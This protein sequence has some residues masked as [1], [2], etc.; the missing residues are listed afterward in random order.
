MCSELFKPSAKIEAITFLWWGLISP[1]RLLFLRRFLCGL[2]SS[3]FL[4]LRS[5]LRHFD[6]PPQFFILV[7]ILL[8]TFSPVLPFTC[9]LI[10]PFRFWLLLISDTICLEMLIG[11]FAFVEM[12]KSLVIDSE[13]KA[14]AVLDH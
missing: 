6:G 1:R 14:V 7:N 2:N 5:L 11:E 9:A 3:F 12:R 10:A 8:T 13:F 4:L